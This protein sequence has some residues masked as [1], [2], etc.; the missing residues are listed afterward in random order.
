M[1]SRSAASAPRSAR[2]ARGSASPRCRAADRAA[3]SRATTSSRRCGSSWNRRM[4]GRL[5]LLELAAGVAVL[6]DERPGRASA[7]AALDVDPAGVADARRSPAP[8]RESRSASTSPTSAAPPPAANTSSVRLGASVTM[9]CGG[10]SRR[11]SRPASSTTRRS[12][13]ACSARPPSAA[14]AR[15]TTHGARAPTPRRPRL[16]RDR[17]AS[18][19]LRRAGHEAR[20][21][22]ARRRSRSR[23]R[24]RAP[25]R[26][27]IE[28]V[29]ARPGDGAAAAV[30]QHERGRPGPRRG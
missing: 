10:R 17:H 22:R 16:H 21:R 11:S 12:R 27:A 25:V 1:R 29:V 2:G 26:S 14:A 3:R 8:R 20:A 19:R 24:T 9:R 6:P 18:A 13:A 15:A 23:R 7:R 5:E 4:P 28:H 30:E